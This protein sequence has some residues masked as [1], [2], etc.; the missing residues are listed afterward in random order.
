M[1]AILTESAAVAN[2]TARA[3]V[4][5]TRDQGTYFYEDSAWK[6]LFVGGDYQWLIDGGLGGRNLDAR[7]LFFYQA[8]VNTPAMVMKTGRRRLAIRLRRIMT[9][10]GT[11][12]TARR[13]T[14]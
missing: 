9:R 10:T 8:T 3:I 1:Q 7:V 11:C 4:F 14:S 2:A 13:T 6:T 5:Q 12:W